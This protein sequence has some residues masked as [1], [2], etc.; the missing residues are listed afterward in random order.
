MHYMPLVCCQF[1]IRGPRI[2][3]VSLVPLNTHSTTQRLSLA[4]FNYVLSPFTTPSVDLFRTVDP[5]RVGSDQGSVSGILDT[6]LFLQDDPALD[7]VEL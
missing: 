2:L 1:R 3:S 7:F 6:E 4:V 5:D